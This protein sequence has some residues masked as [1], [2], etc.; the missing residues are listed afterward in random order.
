M[1]NPA[2]R[3]GD[4]DGRAVDATLERV[5]ALQQTGLLRNLLDRRRLD[6]RRERRAA[7]CL[8][9][10]ES[11]RAAWRPPD[12]CIAL[13][14]IFWDEEDHWPVAAWLTVSRHDGSAWMTAWPSL[15]DHTRDALVQAGGHAVAWL[16]RVTGVETAFLPH[17]YRLAVL[18][19]AG[20]PFPDD[21]VLDGPSFTGAF[22]VAVIALLT[23]RELTTD[24]W[25]LGQ[26]N[27]TGTVSPVGRLAAKLEAI[28]REGL[29]CRRLILAAPAGG[30]PAGIEGCRVT[31]IPAGESFDRLPSTVW[32]DAGP[33]KDLSPLFLTAG[34]PEVLLSALENRQETSAIKELVRW[35]DAT[36]APPRPRFQARRTL[37]AVANR[38]GEI[39]T[40]LESMKSALAIAQGCLDTQQIDF[41]DY[42][43]L[44]NNLGVLY[45]D[46]HEW[47]PAGRWLR[48]G[49]RHLAG[50]RSYTAREQEARL[51]SSLGQMHVWRGRPEQGVPLLRQAL[52]FLGAGRNLNHL[53][54]ALVCRHRAAK[55][56]GAR[57]S[58]AWLDEAE[59]LLAH[60]RR[61]PRY[62]SETEFLFH[63]AFVIYWEARLA[64]ERGEC[65]SALL[66]EILD[67]R[68]QSPHSLFPLAGAA[69]WLSSGREFST[70]SEEPAAAAM[71]LLAEL[72]QGEGVIHHLLSLG[73]TARLWVS[74]LDRESLLGAWKGWR[75]GKGGPLGIPQAG[76]RSSAPDRPATG[77]DQRVIRQAL[78]V[79]ARL[80]PLSDSFAAELAWCRNRLGE[81][82]ASTGRRRSET[83]SARGS[84]PD[85]IRFLSALAEKIAY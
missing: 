34:D 56:S 81:D 35:L 69:C 62:R 73:W 67:L 60:S 18:G 31:R 13:P 70:L 21:L 11:L 77:R 30:I 80:E 8:A 76:S 43:E 39:A 3:T 68:R 78:D 57:I 2:V 32:P 16:R 6:P 37:G 71:E 41:W 10:L 85:T 23:G 75:A 19:P 79:L 47:D 53:A 26:L 51:R 58:P 14:V 9:R 54:G 4:G 45:T 15:T 24:L 44:C 52:A 64:H 63:R 36:G 29:P 17:Q 84:E 72:I 48:K 22:A 46:I 25:V 12:G 42:T 5:I 7:E 66:G 59:A 55:R 61:W 82:L 74:G 38:Q 50:Q 20:H 49:L 40:A 28:A 33:P 1:E 27:R 83:Q 65:S